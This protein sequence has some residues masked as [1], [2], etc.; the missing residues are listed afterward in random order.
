MRAVRQQLF[1]GASQ[2]KIA[3]AGGVSSLTDPLYV[4]E[5][6]DEEI[7]AAVK[8]AEDY[9]TYVLAHSHRG[10]GVIRAINNGVR[11]I[12][13]GSV[14]NDEAAQ[15][16]AEEGVVLNIN[17]EILEQFKPLYTDPIRK[18]KLDEAREGTAESM[19]LAATSGL[20]RSV[21]VQG[22]LHWTDPTGRCDC[23]SSSCSP[24]RR[25]HAG[26]RKLVRGL[27]TATHRL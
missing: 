5:Y 19:R 7:A 25:R 9:G 6:T 11:S 15:L 26:R 17:L 27:S 24:S 18:G 3:T 8:A 14:L 10:E 1:L 13:H 2:I 23:S 12:E 21:A 20:S 16:M 4:I 22:R